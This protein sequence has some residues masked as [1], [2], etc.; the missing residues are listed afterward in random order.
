MSSSHI[1]SYVFEMV[2]DALSNLVLHDN[3]K[4]ASY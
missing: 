2:I 3:V 1:A 4:N